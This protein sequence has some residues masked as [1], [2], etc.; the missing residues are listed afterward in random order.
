MQKVLKLF[1]ASC[2]ALVAFVESAASVQSSGRAAYNVRAANPQGTQSA[3]MPTMPKLPINTLGNIVTDMP[4]GEVPDMPPVPPQPDI[5]DVPDTPT[6]ECPDGGV[7]NSEYTVEKCMNDVLN[8]VNN[9]ALPGGLNDMFNEDLRNAIVNGMGLCS[10]QVER[11]VTEVRRNCANVYRSASDVW[12][13]FNAR[14]VQPE[15][16]NFVLRKTGLTPNQAEN[17]CWL[18]DKNTYGPSFAA[19][20]NDGRTTAEY[21][22]NVGAYNSQ[23][24]NILIKT[25][26][27][28]VN[29][30]NNNPGV[31]GQRGHYARWDATTATCYIRVAAYNKD[32]HITN[33]WLF[34][35]LGDDKPAEVWKAAG[36]TFSCNKDLFGFSLMNDTSTV[37]VVGVGGGTLVGAGVGAIAGHGKRD[38]DCTRESHLKEL[39]EQLRATGKIGTLNQY[40]DI[41]DRVS[42]TGGQITV[43]Q[44]EAIL[45]LYNT[46]D[47]YAV[48]V[49]ACQDVEVYREE[50]SLE[51]SLGCENY[52]NI[53][54]DCFAEHEVSKACVGHNFKSAQECLDFLA[55]E[56]MAGAGVSGECTFKPFN[57][58]K[59]EGTGIYC[60][61][62]AST[63]CRLPGE[64]R[65]ELTPLDGIFESLTILKGEKSNMAKSIGIGA[66]VGAGTGGLATAIT[67]FVERNNINCRVGDGLEQVGFGK[68]HSI[69]SLKDFYVKWNL[70]LPDTVAPTATIT[71]CASWKNTC[72]TFTDLGQCTAAQF[73][74]KPVD[75]PTV[76]LVRS[77]CAVSGSACV[78]NYP[79]A[80]SYGA[81]E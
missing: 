22:K 24:G 78:E 46:Y 58:D 45:D 63:G 72:A 44:C 37:A 54:E 80:K 28:G 67:A 47:E 56:F 66:A 15:Y 51:I 60:S 26:P 53:D 79:V 64:I 43:S 76:T 68:S 55:K 81:C 50:V 52:T 61:A 7:K 70:R 42:T 71:D 75:A 57:L 48:A 65:K 41:S 14:K 1:G 30:N 38:F 73:N 3:R 49:E 17:T 21:N 6:P 20:A 16:Y 2:L 4:S 74:Y 35:A 18:L 23:Q 40:L 36:D 77:A 19:V 34:G 33:S 9:G 39:T 32:K 29:V 27:Q 69:G 62:S 25:A 11:C 13:D 5:P 8:C 59:L 12:I 31:D 10:Y